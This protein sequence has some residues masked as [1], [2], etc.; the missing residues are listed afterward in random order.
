M[1]L[2]IADGFVREIIMDYPMNVSTGEIARIMDEAID[3]ALNI[4]AIN[5][6][7][8][9]KVF[10]GENGKISSIET[11]T[12][13]LIKTKTEFTKIFLT[14]IKKYGNNIKITVPI[15]T[16]IGNEYT[17]GRGPNITFDL[18]FTCTLDTQLKSFFIDAGVNNTLHTM[19][20]HV[21]TDIYI[22]I[23]WGYNSKTVSTKYILAET[24]IVGDVPEAFTNI[25]GAD[26]EIT[27]DIVDHGAEI[28]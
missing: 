20:L 11:N 6:N 26:D 14:K 10:Y 3:D 5:P 7:S 1:I 24:A 13:E 25:H 12:R 27:D 15:G 22:I 16:L 21:T 18:Q 9:D 17:L 23:P 8:I 4:S 19:E 2:I 28:K